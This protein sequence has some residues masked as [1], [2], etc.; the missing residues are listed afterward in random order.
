M[1][2]FLNPLRALALACALHA[3]AHAA[4]TFTFT[5]IRHAGYERTN[6]WDINNSGKVVGSS[7]NDAS[8]VISS[9]VYASGSFTTLSGPA[10]AVSTSAFG[11]SES[12]TIVG[13]YAATWIVE[14]DGFSHLGPSSGFIFS[15]GSYT[16]IDVPGA[17]STVPRA[18]SPDGRY[19]SGY[20]YT[21]TGGSG[22][23]YDR[24]TMTFTSIGV[25]KP[26]V[27][28]AQGVTNDGLV[29][30][31]ET[32]IDESTGM[33]SAPAFIYN[34]ATG[35][36]TDV[37]IPGAARSAFRAI[38]S[39]GRISGF[40]RDADDNAYGFTGYPGS[41]VEI[42]YPGA[43]STYIQGTND[44]GVLVGSFDDAKTAGFIATPVT[45]AIPEPETWALMAAGIVLLVGVRRRRY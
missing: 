10:G 44:A 8:E 3:S 41:F 2:V 35:T 22:F 1:S 30:G 9:F 4:T 5:E 19:I 39:T 33:V 16:T 37:F 15:G 32:T 31:S 38:D 24:T 20:Y 27:F 28:I 18:I 7:Y 13:S 11:I 29:V 42:A 25:P 17:T 12:G 43:T 6:V 36:R 14:S 40:Y 26:G 23:L 34:H 45:A 21:A